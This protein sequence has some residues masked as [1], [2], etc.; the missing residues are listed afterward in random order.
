MMARL[1]R[2]AIFGA[3]WMQTEPS[4][5]RERPVQSNIATEAL[6]QHG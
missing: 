4:G 3:M 2:R 6:G 1:R 5:S